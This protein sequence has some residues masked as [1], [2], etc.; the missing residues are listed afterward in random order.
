VEE[1][2]ANTSSGARVYQRGLQHHHIISYM[3]TTTGSESKNGLFAATV[4]TGAMAAVAAASFGFYTHDAV[5]LLLVRSSDNN[6]G[7]ARV[8]GR[9]SKME[10]S[11]QQQQQ[12]ETSVLN[13]MSVSLDMT[14]A[15]L[16]HL[17][18]ALERARL[19]LPPLPLPPRRSATR[20]SATMQQQR[21]GA[22]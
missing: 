17:D 10:Q 22:R 19:L 16:G 9:L 12:R 15:K 3:V 8:E 2:N 18:K 1:D 7:N 11:M 6:A 14:N 20:R 5:A 21:Q 13:Q 4:T